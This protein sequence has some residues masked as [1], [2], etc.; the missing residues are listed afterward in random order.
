M[1]TLEYATPADVQAVADSL[2]ELKA[3]VE[4]IPDPTSPPDLSALTAR[5][6]QAQADV[7]TLANRVLKTETDITTMKNS[8]GTG[9]SYQ[10]Y[11]PRVPVEKLGSTDSERSAKVVEIMNNIGPTS[12]FPEL[13][14]PI[15]VFRLDRPLPT[16]AG[17]RSIGTVTPASEFNTGAVIQYVGPGPSMFTLKLEAGKYNYPGGGASRDS[18]WHGIQFNGGN[19]KDLLPAP[20]STAFD[21]RYVQWYYT[22]ENCGFVGWD[23]IA[24]GWGTGLNVIGKTHLQA[25]DA[26]TWLGGSECDWFGPGSLADSGNLHGDLP[27]IDWSVSKSTIGQAMLSARNDSYQLKVSGGHNSAAK[28]TK[29]DSPDA[30]PIQGHNVRFKGSA[31]NF[32][33][34]IC[35]FKG[36]RGI[37]CESGSTEVIVAGNGFHGTH[38]ESVAQCDPGFNGLLIWDINSYG[39]AKRVIVADRLEQVLCLDPR[40]TVRRPDGT[41]LKA[42]TITR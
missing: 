4:A 3:E 36:G 29:F 16:D 9:G 12:P 6:D 26:P 8:G 42:A 20:P 5:V 10:V 19:D 37:R 39:N 35:S 14:W 13:Q 28:G 7:A 34:E 30:Q 25:S 40:V 22:F 15:R 1:A 32:A 11:D 31:V 2:A 27:C 23:G 18:H 33:V 24:N 41:V 17:S 38:G 21:S